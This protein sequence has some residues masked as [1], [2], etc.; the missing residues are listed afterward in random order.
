M[1]YQ[2]IL[3]GQSPG[4]NH[5][6]CYAECV[7]VHPKGS[8]GVTPPP[9]HIQL[10]EDGCSSQVLGACLVRGLDFPQSGVLFD[11]TTLQG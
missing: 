9:V 8:L 6:S 10:G 4:E 3:L 11:L 7:T 5:Q 2:I 1:G